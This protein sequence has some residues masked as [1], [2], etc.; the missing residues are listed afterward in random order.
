MVECGKVGRTGG[1]IANLTVHMGYWLD[2]GLTQPHM[3]HWLDPEL[4]LL[5][6]WGLPCVLMDFL[7]ILWFPLTVQNHAGRWIGCALVFE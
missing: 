4:R 2:P 7:Q 5:S 1:G 3:G 6:V